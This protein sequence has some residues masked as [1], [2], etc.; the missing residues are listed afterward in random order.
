MAAFQLSPSQFA[1]QTT[2]PRP[3]VSHILSGRN[4]PSLE[5]VQKILAAYPE[6]AIDWL[7][8]GRGPMLSSS[9]EPE[10]PTPQRGIPAAAAPSPSSPE[11]PSEQQDP[12][13]ASKRPSASRAARV[14]SAPATPPQPRQRAPEAASYAPSADP[15]PPYYPPFTPPGYDQAPAVPPPAYQQPAPT[16]QSAPPPVP[17][18]MPSGAL[19]PAPPVAAQQAVRPDKSVRRILVFY[20]DGT[21]SD[22]RPLAPEDNPFLW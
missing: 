5:A 1:D 16:Y 12:P 19:Y 21:F 18:T 13:A 14:S 6:V 15:V 17:S 9:P 4:K 22:H 7:L 11:P 8:N 10:I 20:S 3:V 2:L